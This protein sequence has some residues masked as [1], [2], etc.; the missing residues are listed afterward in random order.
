MHRQGPIER[1]RFLFLFIVLIAYFLFQSI[2]I[3]AHYH[4]VTNILF[5]VLIAYSLFVIG[6]ERRFLMLTLVLAALANAV[7]FIAVTW[8]NSHALELLRA[9]FGLLFFFL[10]TYACF[11]FMIHD[12]KITITTLFG[13]M[14]SYL[15]IGLS[16][17]YI[18]M[19]II[20]LDP[21]A[22]SGIDIA[23][24][25]LENEL[26]YYSFVTLTTLGYGDIIPDHS[27]AQTVSW[28]EAYTGQVFLTVV[29]AFLVGRFLSGQEL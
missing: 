12:K 8:F 3:Q 10:M 7:T 23:H 24:A 21:M 26:I 2:G 27:I 14:C 28:I 19:L 18:Y 22:F 15:F 4:E 11:T 20:N 16:F 25:N 13:A 1:F 6:K 5:L 9:L 17:T 29:M